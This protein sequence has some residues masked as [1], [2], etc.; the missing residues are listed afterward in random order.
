M[1]ASAHVCTSVWRPEISVGCLLLSSTF[2]S[3]EWT[4]DWYFRIKAE[5]G[6]LSFPTLIV[7]RKCFLELTGRQTLLRDQCW[8]LALPS[9]L[10]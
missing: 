5:A 7:A 2:C 6:F 10:M 1:H 4:S 9:A 3:Q 8:D